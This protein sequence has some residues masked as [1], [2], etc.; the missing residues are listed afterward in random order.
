M[1]KNE[2]LKF[3]ECL[4]N[5]GEYVNFGDHVYDKDT[6]GRSWKSVG[7][8]PKA[9]FFTINPLEKDKTRADSNV[10]ALRNFLFEIDEVPLEEQIPL[11]AK[12]KFPF[13][14]MVYSGRKSY[15]LILSLKED[16]V[17][18]EDY[19]AI[20]KS[21]SQV[22]QKYGAIVDKKCKNPSR[23]SR[24]GGGKRDNGVVQEIKKI[25]GR[26]P[27]KRVEKWLEDNGV[28]WEDNLPDL[29][30]NTDV[31]TS[32]ADADLKMDW[33]M[34]YK[35]KNQRYEKGNH[36]N[37]QFVLARMLKNTGLDINTTTALIYKQCGEIHDGGAP[38]KSAY[39]SKYNT[40]PAIYVPTM[41]DRKAYWEEKN[42]EAAAK[43]T[44]ERF[45]NDT[46]DVLDLD[47]E[48]INRYIRVGTEY[49]KN[50]PEMNVLI[51]WDRGTF[52]EDYGSQA[53]PP[54]CYDGFFYEPDYTSETP[55]IET[56]KHNQ[57]RNH[58]QR[59]NYVLSS[60]EFPT[61][62][63]ALEHGFGE[64]YDLI[65][66]WCAVS[67][68]YPKQKLPAI[69]LVG[70]EDVGKSA[71]IKI[72][73]N[74]MGV[75]NSVAVK[76]K[77]FESQFNSWIENT[78]LVIIEEAGQ[79]KNPDEV[80]DE[81]KRLITE[82]DPILIDRKNKAQYKTHFHGKFILSSNNLSPLKMK[83]A[84]TRFWVREITE[85]PKRTEDYYGKVEKEMGHFMHHLVN[86]VG[87]TLEY[88]VKPRLYFEPEEFHT[89]AKDFIR[90]YNKG[91]I[92]EKIRDT[93][94][95]FFEQFEDEECNFDLGSLKE[96][97][98]LDE[99]D[100]KIKECLAFEFGIKTR[101]GNTWR[102][103]SFRFDPEVVP[104]VFETESRPKRKARWFTAKREKIV[105]K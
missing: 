77:D 96:A 1:E 86:V 48:S 25:V 89:A 51:P 90:D 84:A 40:D 53:R 75:I 41:E 66:K 70:T 2:Q 78:Q 27:L 32:D 82:T 91:E 73:V 11:F 14:T 30:A 71:I 12:A 60:G 15:H 55:L 83:G 28:N 58:F 20:W 92:Y 39:D 67:I 44:S 62:K 8:K 64:Q 61:I 87:P 104:S 9:Q 103:D 63:G 68:L 4:F 23:Y 13:S 105:R 17:S 85:L 47:Y 97:T 33:I 3:L 76:A 88:P 21:I 52:R 18:R 59:P 57:Y 56:G 24:L 54:R 43:D 7:R 31:H 81:F 34:K 19:D 95:D 10:S 99:G 22:L 69:I 5:P 74:L 93:F 94:E 50:D 42:K 49:Y 16:L 72:F 46:Q 26:H 102:Y 38:I 29:N 98:G 80:A 36:N 79:W 101:T 35:M 65:L 45:T 6:K 37:Y 100:K